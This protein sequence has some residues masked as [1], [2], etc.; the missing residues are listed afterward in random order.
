MLPKI[1]DDA[2]IKVLLPSIDAQGALRDMFAE[3]AANKAVQPPQTVTLFPSNAGDVITYQGA[4]EKHN[5]F[6]AKLS[7]Y[8]VNSG[9]PIITAWTLLMSLETGQPL[10]LCDSARLT[11]ERTAATTALA[12]DLLS[13]ST[14]T[15]LAIIGAGTIAQAHW[16]HV[17][18]LRDWKQVKVWSPSLN[19][20]EQK[21]KNWLKR[22]SSVEVTNSADDAIQDADVILLCTSSGTPVIDTSFIEGGVLV[23]SISTN[24]ANA[25]EVPP[26]FLLNA[27]VYCDYR[28]TTPNA[29]GEMVFAANECGWKPDQ[30]VGDLAELIDGQCA[31]PDQSAPIFFRS[32]GLGLEDIAIANQIYLESDK[33]EN[34]KQ[35]K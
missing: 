12:L 3:L 6:G 25:H 30:L 14:S 29:A 31:Y 21:K 16:R 28:E 19:D 2:A 22:G 7:P 20:D 17:E 33:H 34:S 35:E 15:K 8:I 5:V 13:K 4:L 11:V 18:H 24:V 1:L 32:L 27:K 26:D 23:T 10:L 9:S